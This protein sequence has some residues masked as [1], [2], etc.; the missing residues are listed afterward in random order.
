MR[1]GVT[2]RAAVR[3][4]AGISASAVLSRVR[5]PDPAAASQGANDLPSGRLVVP[6][7]RELVLVP[8]DGSGEQTV[9]SVGAG[10]FVTDVAWAPNGSRVVFSRYSARQGEGA[11]GAD[12]A[13]VPVPGDGGPPGVLVARDRAGTLLA[14]PAWAPD[15]GG[16]AFENAGYS[17]S[18]GLVLRIE[19]VAADGADRRVLVEG[20]R[21]PAIS[22][23]GA[24]V[25]FVKTLSSGDGLWVRPLAGGS[26]RQVVAEYELLAIAFPRFSPDGKQIAFAGIGEPARGPARRL[27]L[28]DRVSTR[29]EPTIRMPGRHGLPWDLFLVDAT[30]A[31]LRRFA[32]LT[33][34][35]AAIAWSPDGRWIAVGGATGLRLVSVPDGA[36]RPLSTAG[37]FGGIDWR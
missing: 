27:D 31:N 12:L 26:E 25:A 3:I 36:I 19:W 6:R 21:N 37:S 11:G 15:G 8:A 4:L 30:G 28:L 20:G 32:L 5:T 7:G 24:T 17:T 2:R 34:D 13:V 33:E 35:D 23:D 1:H 10:E 29:A 14:A 22:P 16:L 18:G 9:V